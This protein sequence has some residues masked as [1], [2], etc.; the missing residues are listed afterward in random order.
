MI[1][2]WKFQHILSTLTKNL[3]RCQLTINYLIQLNYIPIHTYWTQ[4]WC[5]S[6]LFITLVFLDELLYIKYIIVKLQSVTYWRHMITK[7]S[8]IERKYKLSNERLQV[9]KIKYLLELLRCMMTKHIIISYLYL[10]IKSL[11][12]HYIIIYQKLIFT[13]EFII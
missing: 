9:V 10:V 5:A 6:S 1:Q 4:K 3:Q 7:P 11:L 13:A 8:T 2:Q 12:I